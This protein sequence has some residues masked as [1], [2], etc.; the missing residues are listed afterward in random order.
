MTTE[1]TEHKDV[2]LRRVFSVLWQSKKSIL[3]ACILAASLSIALAL[4]LPNTY[5]SEVLLAPTADPSGFKMS[6]Q[7]SGLAS[8]AG[9]NLGGQGQ[10]N[11]AL[12]LEIIQSREFLGRFIEKHDL[13]VPV[14]AAN[15]WDRDTNTLKINDSIYDTNK[16]LWV[17]EVKPP[18]QPKPSVLETVEDFSDLLSVSQDKTTGMVK[19]SLQHYSPFLVKEW[20]DA[21]VKDLNEDVRRRDLEQ[22]QKSVDYL[23]AKAAETNVAE[24]KELLY[25]LIEEQTKTLMLGHVRDEYVF[26]TVDPAF[27][28]EKKN[29]PKRAL[30]VIGITMATFF[31]ACFVVLVRRASKVSSR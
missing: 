10:D 2:D 31:I 24:L 30:I 25:S 7:L 6:R 12:A 9:L 4:S 11:T 13:F 1:Q 18:F 27:V 5:K 20:L 23:S 15:G 26:K 29:K 3:I 17:R 8:L 21:L 22:A 28:A 16:K 14:M 19:V